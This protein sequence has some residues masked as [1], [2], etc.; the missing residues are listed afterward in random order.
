MSLTGEFLVNYF[1]SEE[2]SGAKRD[3]DP[4]HDGPTGTDDPTGTGSGIGTQHPAKTDL[5]IRR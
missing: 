1:N 3:D 2:G 4:R 5:A